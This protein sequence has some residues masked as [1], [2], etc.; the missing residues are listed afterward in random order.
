MWTVIVFEC[1]NAY[2]KKGSYWCCNEFERK[3][4]MVDCYISANSQ[5]AYENEKYYK[6][7]DCFIDLLII[8]IQVDVL[9]RSSIR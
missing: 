9:F 2:N 7:G 1:I 8:I 3:N 4:I 6:T 5:Y